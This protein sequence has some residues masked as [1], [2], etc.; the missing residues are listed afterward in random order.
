MCATARR[1]LAKADTL[2][3]A[4][5]G[6][7]QGRSAADFIYHPCHANGGDQVQKKRANAPKREVRFAP[8]NGHRK[9]DVAC[10]KTCTISDIARSETTRQREANRQRFGG[11]NVAV[12]N[13]VDRLAR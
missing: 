11:M 1:Q 5:S 4:F 8:I 10:S 12:G 13:A 2:R 9:R 3:A 7:A 6:S